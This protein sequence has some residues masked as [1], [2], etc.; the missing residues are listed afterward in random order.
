ME[1]SVLAAADPNP[2]ARAATTSG[3]VIEVRGLVRTFEGGI[4]AVRGIDLSVSPG[5]VFGFLGPNGAGKT[6]TVRMLCTLLP[7]TSGTREGC[8]LRRRPEPRCGA[9]PDR[10]GAPG[11]R[12]RPGPDR[13]RAARASVR[14]VRDHRQKRQGAHRRA[15][16][17]GRA[18]RGRRPPDQDLL[19][20]N[21]APARPRERAGAF[22]R[23]AVPRRADHRPRPRFASDC[24]GR[25]PPRQ[26]IRHDR[27]PDDAVP[28]GGRQ[29][30]QSAGDHRRRPD[31]D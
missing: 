9:P 26:G 3:A 4:E 14:A 8:R 19:G 11:D 18:D 29:P 24:L 13:A 27:V 7:P 21:E 17:A 23:G 22:A 12:P 1:R 5:E 28:R 31:R 30:L 6:T 25:G 16:G 15:A 10:R 20:R 2:R